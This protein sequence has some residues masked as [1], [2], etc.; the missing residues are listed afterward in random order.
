MNKIKD[1]FNKYHEIIMYVFIG[2]LT[3]LVSLASY[4]LLTFT[5]FDANNPLQLQIANIISWIL[6][7]SFAFIANRKYVFRSNNS[8]IGKECFDFF[9]AR[10]STLVIDMMAMGL[11]VSILNINDSLA[12][13]I[14]QFII[15][16]LNYLF[17][18]FLVFQNESN[19]QIKNVLNDNIFIILMIFMFILL[20]YFFP[21]SGDDWAWGTQIGIDRLSTW[22]D[23]YNGRYAGNLLI[24]ILSRSKI[25]RIIV[26]TL[27]FVLIVRYIYKITNTKNKSYIL[28]SSILLLLMPVTILRETVTWASGFANYVLPILLILF[29]IYKNIELLNNKQSFNDKN[30]LKLI[31]YFII[32]FIGSLFIENVTLYNLFLI[33]IILMYEKIKF[34]KFSVANIVYFIGSLFGTI[35]MFSNSVYLN[36]FNHNDGYRT[37]T[38]DNIIISSVKK[39]V[40]VLTDYIFTHNVIVGIVLCLCVIMVIFKYKSKNNKISNKKRVLLNLSLMF[41][42]LYLF[43]ILYLNLPLTEH[44]LNYPMRWI[45][46][47]GISLLMVLSLIIVSVNC[48]DDKFKCCKILFYIFS[49]VVV[50]LPLLVITPVGPR[51]FLTTYIFYILII[52]EMLD[53]LFGNK[54]SCIDYLL[55]IIIVIAFS[56]LLAIYY[57]IHKIDVIQT[58]YIEKVKET[59]TNIDLPLIPHENYV[60]CINMTDDIFGYRY[61]LFHGIDENITINFIS[62]TEWKEK[63]KNN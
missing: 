14:V 1:L 34:K 53:C 45:Y 19:N 21:Y 15:L 29:I 62:Y 17:S 24:L 28:I 40:T 58:K 13:I 57:S 35:M 33:T 54:I 47:C 20:C 50:N 2:G 25:I 9:L 39:F 23:N 44:F 55:K 12:K 18:K 42:T 26:E 8:N 6:C 5:I 3:T 52:I 60:H 41:V 31:L 36:I 10:V 48:I 27:A 59:S 37:I 30:I 46:N 61:K 4:Y 38:T 56:Y 16:I 49:I 63:V 43:N 11:M 51:L 22:F 32:S 7:V